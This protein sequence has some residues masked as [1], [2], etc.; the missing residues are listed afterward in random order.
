MET[1]PQE[2]STG[3]SPGRSL[4]DR[5]RDSATAQLSTQK[6]RATE[7]LGTIARA[8]RDT[9]EPLRNNQQDAIAQYVE[10]AAEQIDRFSNQLRERDVRELIGDAQRFARRQP[11]LF[12]GA[13][14]AAGMLAARFLKSSSDASP[15]AYGSP[16]A[17][18]AYAYPDA[19]ERSAYG[20]ATGETRYAGGGL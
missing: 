11:A 8:V 16:S 3:A 4:I 6:D 14:F 5:V 7:S 13:A 12:I 20:G 19:R 10:R 1:S 17:G 18:G 9:T 15:R 2:R